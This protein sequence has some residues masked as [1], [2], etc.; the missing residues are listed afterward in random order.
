MR[1]SVLAAFAA[2]GAV[3]DLPSTWASSPQCTSAGGGM[4][5]CP[6]FGLTS[7]NQEYQRNTTTMIILNSNNIAQIGTSDFDGLSL[8]DILV[9]SS[10]A[11]SYI[12]DD[13]FN[14]LANL[15]QL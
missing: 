5:N 9:L 7:A 12:T 2:F 11:I 4:Y 10:N 14:G 6:F 8:L 15:K 3:V 1:F 13:A